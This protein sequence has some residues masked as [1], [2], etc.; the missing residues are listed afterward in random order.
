VSDLVDY[1]V[2]SLARD[3]D[4]VRVNVV[5]GEAS[6]LY[7]VDL[8]DADR[9]RLLANDSAL[10]HAMRQVLSAAGG[11]HKAVLELVADHGEEAAAEE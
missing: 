3:E 4:A 2:R 6:M 7:E 10:L 11:R 8:S 1:M 5:E 9:A